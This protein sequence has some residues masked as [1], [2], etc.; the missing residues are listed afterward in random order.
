[1]ERV[2]TNK[3][4]YLLKRGFDITI[5][6]TD[7]QQRQPYFELDPRVDVIDLGIDYQDN[8][9]SNLY[10]KLYSYPG[11]LRLHRK[12]LENILMN[13]RPDI[14]ISLF[15]HDAGFLWKIKDGSKKLLEVHFSRFKRIQYGKKGIWGL[16]NSYRSRLDRRYAKKYD[17][18]I[19]LTEEDRQYWGKLHNIAVIPNANTFGS[20]RQAAL[21]QKTV[22][23]VGRYDQQKQFDQLIEAWAML[24]ADFPEWKL[25]I[26]GQGELANYL[27][28]CITQHGLAQVVQLCRPVKEIEQEYLNSS[29]V[30]LTSRYEGLPMALLEAQACGLPMVSYACKCGPRDIIAQGHN[31]FLVKKDDPKAFADSLKLLM[32]NDS[33]RQQM[34][35]NAKLFSHRFTEDTVMQK[36]IN[37]F[38]GLAH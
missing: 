38:N 33:L 9:G 6:T 2:L 28:N 1:M 32:R 27:Q 14:T 5:I 23:A 20:E 4:N 18:F 12:R 19:V 13:L 34:G 29:I 26:F 8:N 15:D 25:R 10:H 16:I 36:W 24:A 37:L 17:R 30:A 3:A 22:I 31:G 35:Y 11:K 7:Q 21:D